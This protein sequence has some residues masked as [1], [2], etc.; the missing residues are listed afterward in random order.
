M[1]NYRL[2]IMGY[3]PF[4]LPPRDSW[5]IVGSGS[6][7]P[8][9][10]QFDGGIIALN[11]AL[12]WIRRADVAI[13]SHYEDFIAAWPFLNKVE[14]VFIA[15]P[16]HVGFRC[17]PVEAINLLN[18]DRLISELPWKVRFFEKESVLSRFLDRSHTLYCEHTIASA[19]LSLLAR[20]NITEAQYFGIDGGS[21]KITG[22]AYEPST[23]ENYDRHKRE[24][25][26]T[27]AQLGVKVKGELVCV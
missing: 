11:S 20:N 9:C 14:L 24:F 27:A 15:D 2:E 7:G 3:G 5:A 1:R 23:G 17:V 22:G 21:W 8:Q 13:L 12:T 19:A 26:R 18:Y 6:S 25:L 10:I 16:L 4:D